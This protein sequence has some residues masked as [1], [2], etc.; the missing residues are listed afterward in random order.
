MVMMENELFGRVWNEWIEIQTRSKCSVRWVRTE[1]YGK[2]N[3][4]RKQMNDRDGP[5]CTESNQEQIM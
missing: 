1:K 2:H 4:R 3:D 5:M